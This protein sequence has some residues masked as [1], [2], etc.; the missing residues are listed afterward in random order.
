MPAENTGNLHIVSI[1]HYIFF[2]NYGLINRG[3]DKVSTT[4]CEAF[5]KKDIPGPQHKYKVSHGLVEERTPFYAT[6]SKCMG[7]DNKFTE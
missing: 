4:T 6:L 7:R 2:I 5:A 1:I 3:L